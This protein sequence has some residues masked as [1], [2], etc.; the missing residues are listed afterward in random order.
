MQSSSSTCGHQSSSGIKWRAEVFMPPPEQSRSGRHR[1]RDPNDR[2]PPLQCHLLTSP[3]GNDYRNQEVGTATT[4]THGARYGSARGSSGWFPW[5]HRATLQQRDLPI[6]IRA[7]TQRREVRA[8]FPLRRIR[9]K[10]LTTINNVVIVNGPLEHQDDTAHR[11]RR[12][13]KKRSNTCS[14]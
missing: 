12:K 2:L 3:A 10:T 11:S 1:A 14:R 5:W 6:V 7:L 13:L 9:I 8:G 4:T